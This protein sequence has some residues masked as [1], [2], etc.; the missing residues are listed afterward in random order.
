VYTA[1]SKSSIVEHDGTNYDMLDPTQVEKFSKSLGLLPAQAKK[2]HDALKLAGD[3]SRDELARIARLW[4]KAELGGR[5]PSRMVLSGHSNGDVFWGERGW[6]T[7]TEISNLADALPKAAAKVEDLMLAGCGC[8]GPG[9]FTEWQTVLPNLKT[10]WGYQKKS[11]ATGDGAEEHQ[12]RWES[13]SR[14][15]SEK[16]TR[17]HAK[18]KRKDYKTVIWTL[19]KGFDD[20]RK[21]EKIDVV[22]S[23]AVAGDPIFN[24]YFTGKKVASSPSEADLREHYNNVRDLVQHSDVKEPEKGQMKLRRDQTLLLLYWSKSVAPGFAKA[25]KLLIEDGY[26]EAGEKKVPDYGA[27]DRKAALAE[28]DRFLKATDTSTSARVKEL[29]AALIK[30]RDLDLSNMPLIQ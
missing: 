6:L 28:I 2:V 24:D 22:R 8:G 10:I 1:A 19:T 27:M 13:V 17:A 12:A 5:M 7:R 29:R 15:R 18:E 26:Q 3:D 16:M 30:L 21:P 23:R 4:A 14:G 11:P 20:G 9:V 25:N